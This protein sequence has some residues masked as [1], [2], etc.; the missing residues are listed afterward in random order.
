M[1][2]GVGLFVEDAA[3]VLQRPRTRYA[4]AAVRP[5]DPFAGRVGAPDVRAKGDHVQLR[6]A[7]GEQAAF[8]SGVDHLQG[9]GLAEL[10]DVNLLAQRE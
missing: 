9:C 4:G 10:R 5:N 6:V 3:V 7:G 2:R 1:A 8:Q